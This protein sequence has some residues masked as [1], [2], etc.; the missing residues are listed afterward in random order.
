MHSLADLPPDEILMEYLLEA[1]KLNDQGVKVTPKKPTDKEKMELTVPDDLQA[2]L[3]KN[4]AARVFFDK[5]P[6]SHRKEHIMWINEAKTLATREKRIDTTVEW[7][8]ERTSRNIYH[9]AIV[10]D[11]FS[12]SL[13]C[14]NKIFH[15]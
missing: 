5:F 4:L 12:Y 11:Y 13:R 8:A 6:W 2:A 3:N 10:W 14:C 9:P 15:S 7:M 1:K